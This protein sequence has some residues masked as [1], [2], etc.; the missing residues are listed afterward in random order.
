MI[1][2][3]RPVAPVGQQAPPMRAAASAVWRALRSAHGTLQLTTGTPSAV[4]DED[5]RE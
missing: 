3:P 5:T 2:A 4:L 1:R